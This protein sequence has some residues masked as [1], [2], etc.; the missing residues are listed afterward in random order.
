MFCD[1]FIITMCCEDG[2][3]QPKPNPNVYG[4][5]W[6]CGRCTFINSS[7]AAACNVCKDKRPSDAAAH[8]THPW[9]CSQ[10]TFDNLAGT[11]CTMCN[12]P[13]PVPT[14]INLNQNGFF[15]SIFVFH[16]PQQIKYAR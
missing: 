4:A 13:K 15:L 10:C 11:Y 12:K 6:K 14:G 7:T 9:R 1:D 2:N 8:A 5:K 3:V 16:F